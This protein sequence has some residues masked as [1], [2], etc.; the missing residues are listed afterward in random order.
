MAQFAGDRH[1]R[2]LI[3]EGIA[4]AVDAIDDH[5]G[6]SFPAVMGKASNGYYDYWRHWSSLY[7]GARFH[8]VPWD[9]YDY[10]N[11]RVASGN[12][13]KVQSLSL[14][15]ELPKRVLDAWK[16][17]RVALTLEAT[18]LYTFCDSRLKGQ[19]PT[20]GGFSEVQLTDTP[21]Y[22]LGLNINF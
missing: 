12:Y 9:M 22:T 5:R 16:M 4:A 15:Y 3:G 20:Q 11:A 14:T 17:Q 7:S 2:D 19:T 6:V 8:E 10:S 18:N 1:V 13:L 21:T